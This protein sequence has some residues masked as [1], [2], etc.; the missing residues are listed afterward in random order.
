MPIGG[1]LVRTL[2]DLG[3]PPE[4]LQEWD[5]WLAQVDGRMKDT[6]PTSHLKVG[7]IE[8]DYGLPQLKVAE[9]II[10]TGE[11]LSTFTWTVPSYGTNLFL[12][13]NAGSQ[14]SA[15]PST[16]CM[17][18][19]G[20]TGNN[21]GYQAMLG[22]HETPAAT[23]L[24]G[25]SKMNLSSLN[26]DD[27]ALSSANAVIV[28]VPNYNNIVLEKMALNLAGRS[29][30]DNAVSST[31]TVMNYWT[32]TSAIRTITLFDIN[33]EDWTIGSMFSLYVIP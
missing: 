11:S 29:T 5:R 4:D 18:F 30:A 16:L 19:N 14:K 25:E 3:M 6:S 1:D 7:M 9:R 32:D 31:G 15:L 17:R 20:D 2:E 12:M 28:W 13:I 21:Y 24:T 10:K 27:N 33:S 23:Q 8:T 22:N 26:G